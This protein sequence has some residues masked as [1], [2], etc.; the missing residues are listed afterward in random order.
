MYL[1]SAP[2]SFKTTEMKKLALFLAA[3]LAACSCSVAYDLSNWKMQK[4]GDSKSYDVKV[5]CTVAGA[6]NEAGV[7]GESVL[8]KD[9][10]FKID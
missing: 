9:R 2:H 6:L 3:A 10:Y 7:F 1:C 5:P 8:D 4:E